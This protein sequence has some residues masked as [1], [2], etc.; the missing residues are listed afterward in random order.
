MTHYTYMILKK[1]YNNTQ[2]GRKREK[3]IK[4]FFPFF[5]RKKIL[6]GELYRFLVSIDVNIDK[7]PLCIYIHIYHLRIIGNTNYTG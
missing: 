6:F 5:K 4:S 3:Y 7:C 2:M 1:I